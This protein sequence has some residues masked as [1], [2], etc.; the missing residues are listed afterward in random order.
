MDRGK[1]PER[2]WVPFAIKYR[3]RIPT[4]WPLI[5]L[6]L[7][8]YLIKNRLL[9]LHTQLVHSKI[10]ASSISKN[11]FLPTPMCQYPTHIHPESHHSETIMGQQASGTYFVVKGSSPHN[12]Q[13]CPGEP[14]GSLFSSIH[15]AHCALFPKEN[16]QAHAETWEQ[17]GV[18]SSAQL[19]VTHLAFCPLFETS[20][21]KINVTLWQEKSPFF[22][23]GLS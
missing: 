18:T 13:E 3:I 23:G 15:T 5:W 14:I 17:A 22:L 21:I 2:R 7:I 9:S 10:R 20:I 12:V 16:T 6:S 1:N 11:S 8:N 19:P 4:L